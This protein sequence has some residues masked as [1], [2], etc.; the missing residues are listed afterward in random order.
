MDEF[1]VYAVCWLLD[2]DQR[3]KQCLYCSMCDAW[4][5]LEDLN[6]WWRRGQAMAI[7]MAQGFEA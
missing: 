2:G 3:F 4:I 1:H 6:D 7:S 5:C